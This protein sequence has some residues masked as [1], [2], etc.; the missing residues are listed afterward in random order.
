MRGQWIGGYTGTNDG[1]LVVNIDELRDK[2]QGIAYV[3]PKLD[4]LPASVVYFQTPDKS[5]KFKINAGRSA[6]VDPLTGLQTYLEAVAEWYPNTVMSKDII[7]DGELQ[8]DGLHLSWSTDIGLVGQAVLPASLAGQKSALPAQQMDWAGFKQYVDKLKGG[9]ELF[10][11]QKEPWRLRTAYHRSGRANMARFMSYDIP[12]LY[13]HLS[14]RTRH[15]F[16][17]NNN[18]E[19][20]AFYGL[21]QHHGYPTPL[22]DWT[23]SP[24]VAAFFAFRQITADELMREDATKKVVRIFVFDQDKWQTDNRVVNIASA[25]PNITVL[26]LLALENDRTLP[27]QAVSLFS[28]IDDLEAWIYRKDGQELLQAIDIPWTERTK[29]MRELRYMG[30]TA[31]A[32]FPG[33]DGACEE[34]KE[35]HFDNDP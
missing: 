20:G 4:L 7:I 13:R 19:N 22:L 5:L 15:F 27:Q 9:N 24:Y 14:H 18:D 33:L 21:I 10:R 28:N 6:P 11:G 25:F 29:V 16:N 35:V 12:Q 17:L 31:G 1:L 32:M 30:I 3:F 26:K 23:L 2:Y 8:K 34:L